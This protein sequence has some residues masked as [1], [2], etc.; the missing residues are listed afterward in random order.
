[1]KR[2]AIVFDFDET[3]SKTHLFAILVGWKE[4]TKSTTN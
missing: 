2:R 4:I 1:M 3:L